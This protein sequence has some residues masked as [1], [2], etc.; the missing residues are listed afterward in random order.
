MADGLFSTD[1]L[2]GNDNSGIKIT[3]VKQ[4][5][6][7]APAMKEVIPDEVHYV[8]T[9]RKCG[10][11]DFTN[12]ATNTSKWGGAGLGAHKVRVCKSC[13]FAEDVPEEDF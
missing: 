6:R 3:E 13:N 4:E 5:K 9:C 11:H 8:F 10:N 7:A 1:E 12:M 2:E